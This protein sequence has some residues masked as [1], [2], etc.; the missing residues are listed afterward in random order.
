MPKKTREQKM[1]SEL[2]RLKRQA[3]PQKS[4]EPPKAKAAE[5]RP[6]IVPSTGYNNVSEVRVAALSSKEASK[7]EIQSYDYSYVTSDLKKIVVLS[8]LTITFEVV[9]NL[10]MRLEFANLLLRRLGIDI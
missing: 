9:L 1:A 3:S 4:W 6:T 8:T 2:R 5:T 10:T 7:T